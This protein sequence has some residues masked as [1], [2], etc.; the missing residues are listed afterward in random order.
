[1]EGEKRVFR[2][3]GDVIECSRL[4]SQ[5]KGAALERD[6]RQLNPDVL[7]GKKETAPL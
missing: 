6:K 2:G 7:C 1:M 4:D 3:E 5:K